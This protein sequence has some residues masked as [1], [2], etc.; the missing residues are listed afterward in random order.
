MRLDSKPYVRRQSCS[1]GSCTKPRILKDRE[2]KKQEGK[3]M[4]PKTKGNE[5]SKNYC[6]NFVATEQIS[7]FLFFDGR[8]AI[9]RCQQVHVLMCAI[10]AISV[11][12]YSSG[13]FHLQEP[14]KM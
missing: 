10:D 9:D 4:T 6:K 14:L 5:E 12:P 13:L 8:G 2:G 11:G 1:K 7:F 3:K